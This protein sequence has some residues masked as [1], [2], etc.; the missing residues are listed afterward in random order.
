MSLKLHTASVTSLYKEPNS[1]KQLQITAVSSHKN[2]SYCIYD[3]N[4]VKPIFLPPAQKILTLDD[5]TGID[6]FHFDALDDSKGRIPSYEKIIADKSP[7]NEVPVK[8][9]MANPPSPNLLP[10]K[11]AYLTIDEPSADYDVKVSPKNG[12]STPTM[13]KEI[14]QERLSSQE[15]EIIQLADVNQVETA[16]L[17]HIKPSTVNLFGTTLVPSR[18]AL[19]VM[20]KNGIRG[21]SNERV[22]MKSRV[23][24]AD[25]ANQTII[26]PGIASPAASM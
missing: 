4:H 21:Q 26:S 1:L 3:N 22:D 15:S 14:D 18:F 6:S 7:Q 19:D 9:L 8:V 10:Q 5:D 25:E 2:V 20:S 12:I 23:F 17:E 13:I 16:V 11:Q 24:S